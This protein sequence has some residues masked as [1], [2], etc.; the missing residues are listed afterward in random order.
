MIAVPPTPAR[1]IADA[2]GANSRIDA[3]TKN[4]PNRSIA[5]NKTRKLPACN[6]GAP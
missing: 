5:P 2:I 1:M 3:N 6:P 4:P